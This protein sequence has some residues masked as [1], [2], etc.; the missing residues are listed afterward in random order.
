MASA[1]SDIFFASTVI[2]HVRMS[3][4]SASEYSLL[5]KKPPK[6]N[7]KVLTTPK[8]VPKKTVSV[9]AFSIAVTLD[10]K[11]KWFDYQVVVCVHKWHKNENFRLYPFQ[12][13]NFDLL[14]LKLLICSSMTK[15]IFSFLCP[16]PT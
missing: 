10:I 14:L 12:K 5:L 1:R 2:F 8:L 16:L 4:Q 3:G 11:S 7:K 6:V 15:N 13:F 9:I